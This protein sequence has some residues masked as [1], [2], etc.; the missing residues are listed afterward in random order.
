MD[1]DGEGRRFSVLEGVEGDGAILIGRGTRVVGEIHDC[2]SIEVQGELEGNVTA[3]RVTIREGGVISGSVQTVEAEIHGVVT[4]ELQVDGL[5]DVHS[6]GRV[7]GNLTYGQIAIAAGGEVSGNIFGPRRISNET[8]AP[9]LANG[10]DPQV[11][12]AS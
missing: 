7:D 3:K 11:T 1:R 8:T 12:L 4:G 6:S 9:A 2:T 10:Q 5:L